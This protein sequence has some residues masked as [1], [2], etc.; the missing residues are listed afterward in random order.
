MVLAG[1]QHAASQH[2]LC[3]DL[4]I[5]GEQAFVS[6]NAALKAGAWEGQASCPC[7]GWPG[8]TCSGDSISQM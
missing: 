1:S 5:A 6:T 7:A 4:P 8:I 3:P 2:S